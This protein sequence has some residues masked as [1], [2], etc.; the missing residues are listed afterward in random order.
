MINIG[1]HRIAYRR[2]SNRD[3][4]GAGTLS[5]LLFLGLLL[6]NRFYMSANLVFFA[7]IFMVLSLVFLA[8]GYKGISVW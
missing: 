1:K 5:A 7:S 3:Y 4:N 8:K 2:L 6:V